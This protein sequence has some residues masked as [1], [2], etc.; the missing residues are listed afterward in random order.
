MDSRHS[1]LESGLGGFTSLDSDIDRLSFLKTSV[2]LQYL[3]L[4][5]LRLRQLYQPD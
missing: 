5:W 2:F 1:V 4:L 3:A